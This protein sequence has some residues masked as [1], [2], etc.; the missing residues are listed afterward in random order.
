MKPSSNPPAETIIVDLIKLPPSVAMIL[1][2]FEATPVTMHG[3]AMHAKQAA[4]ARSLLPAAWATASGDR[5]A[6]EVGF[7]LEP[8]RKVK[9]RACSTTKTM[10]CENILD[11]SFLL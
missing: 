2:E 6:Q 10:G 11:A 4:K 3:A 1:I 8:Q 5:N 7:Q 9:F